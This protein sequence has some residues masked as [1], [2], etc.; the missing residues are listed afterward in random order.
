M[1]RPPASVTVTIANGDP[2]MP[3]PCLGT[4]PM[5]AAER[6][7][8]HRAKLRQSPDTAGA[9][10]APRIPP[11]PRRWK[12]AVTALLALQDEYRDWLDRLPE[13]LEGSRTAEKLQAIAELDI[14]ELLAVDPP[15]GYRRD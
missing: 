4:L 6:Q 7:A 3:T 13:N 2:A 15:R 11:R 5:T 8:R 14:E 12:A 9:A 10:P 1:I